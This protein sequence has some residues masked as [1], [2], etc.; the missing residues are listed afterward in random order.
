MVRARICAVSP[1]RR[2]GLG[3]VVGALTLASLLLPEPVDAASQVRAVRF[4]PG[5][6]STRLTLETATAAEFRTLT[7]S[8]PL[9]VVVDLPGFVTGGGLDQLASRIPAD[10]PLVVRAR[11][12]QFKPDIVRI[13]LE[14]RQ[15][16]S[17]KAFAVPPAGDYGHRVVV[18][19]LPGA[20]AAANPGDAATTPAEPLTAP[21]S[22]NPPLAEAQ[23]GNRTSTPARGDPRS[24]SLKPEPNRP[25]PNRSE[26]GR[27]VAD[28]RFDRLV[29]IAIDAGHGGE[30]PG[31]RGPS[32]LVEKE[33]TLAVARRL[34]ALM[35]AEPGLRGVLVRDDDYFIPLQGRTAKAR[36]LR[37][38]LFVS[39]HADAFIRP[40]A[41]GSSVFVL[42][43][44]GASSA[45][46]RWLAKRE[47]DADLIGGVRAET[48]G[49][50]LER[51]LYDLQQDRSRNDSV[52]LAG[53]VLGELS[54]LNRLHRDG[55][56]FAGFAVLKS[57]DI[58]SILVETAFI[59][60]PAEERKLADPAHQDQ[61]ARAILAGIKRFLADNPTL[62]RPS[63]LT[64]RDAPAP[65]GSRV[66]QGKVLLAARQSGGRPL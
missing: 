48:R 51:T 23:P 63:K 32:G 35:D 8:D 4:W 5:P 14:L 28:T 25:E 21:P 12:A 41:A 57:H 49:V 6:E 55:I 53:H 64:Q 36:A 58:P 29:T 47:N 60:N 7:L 19:L 26:P 20:G 37:A 54:Q 44:N 13:V 65:G 39:I 16:V 56:E 9:R 31:A 33:V 30:D 18:D 46:A 45:A 27:L 11:A 38:D 43:E 2:L 62:A 3:L 1:A 15:P 24:D 22:A 40:D 61:L 34:K 52:K 59:T 17:V 50:I 10:N 66:R 42:S